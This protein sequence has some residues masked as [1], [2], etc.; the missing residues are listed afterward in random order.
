MADSTGLH[1]DWAASC[2]EWDPASG[3]WR[4]ENGGPADTVR[5]DISTAGLP[6][7]QAYDFWRN[8]VF[9]NFSARR[10]NDEQRRRYHAEGT[11]FFTAGA[12]I[13]ISSTDS[14]FGGRHMAHH[15][16]DGLDDITIGYIAEG[17]RWQVDEDGEHRA[18]AGEFYV[19][20]AARASEVGW[21]R[22]GGVYLALSR[23][24]ALRAGCP[25]DMT[26][27]ML[28]RMLAKSPVAPFLA[29]QFALLWRQGRGMSG[30]DMG[31]LFPAMTALAQAALAP[32]G[33]PETEGFEPG[34]LAAACRFI[35]AHLGDEDLSPDRIA[36]AIGCSRATLYR[37]F[38]DHPMTIAEYVRECRLQ[39]AMTALSRRPGGSVSAVAAR[40]GF[41][42]PSTFS[43]AFRRRFGVSPRDVGRSPVP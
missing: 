39:A 36:A 10:P 3:P 16:A 22:G 11:G 21:S 42:D 6:G 37:L 38:A 30:A 1:W 41:T 32:A 4:P 31:H 34:R 5:L 20:D 26:P 27:N 12:S 13:G 15:R 25:P 19:Y 29:A 40:L 18:C 7:N 43:Q 9:Y 2:W 8:M 14:L 28:A 23:E 33:T 35:R 24:T 17:M